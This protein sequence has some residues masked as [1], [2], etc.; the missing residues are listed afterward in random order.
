MVFR[1]IHTSNLIRKPLTSNKR[2]KQLAHI[3]YA[4]HYKN[5]N[6][7]LAIPELGIIIGQK[8]WSEKEKV[9]TYCSVAC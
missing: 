5:K 4:K 2:A 9:N 7:I 1:Y 6:N 3:K 8:L